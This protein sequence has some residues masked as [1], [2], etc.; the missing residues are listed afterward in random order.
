MKKL[1]L[2]LCCA[3]ALLCCGCMPNTQLE[4]RAIVQAV[5]VD[6]FEDEYHLTLQLFDSGGT[7]ENAGGSDAYQLAQGSGPSLTQAI[8]QLAQSG[9]EVYLGSCQV[10]VL[11]S[12][13]MPKLRDVLD[14]FNSR[15]Q[16]RATMMVCS[17]DGTA[18]DVLNIADGKAK[19]SPAV[20][21]EQELRLGEE[22]KRLPACRLLNILSAL[23]TDGYDGVLPLLGVEGKSGDARPVLKGAVV[24]RGEA[25]LL[26]LSTGEAQ[27]LATAHPGR[28]S[29]GMELQTDGASGVSVLLEDFDAKLKAEW[30]DD[31]LHLWV[32]VKLKG[33]V[34]EWEGMAVD[35]LSQEQLTDAQQKAARQT[36][37]EWN[38]LLQKL[39][40]SGCDPL[41]FGER[42]QRR[43][44]ND[45][46][47]LD[48]RQWPTLLQKA[49]WDIRVT[50]TLTTFSG[51]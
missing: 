21:C 27:L 30:K 43:H 36:V 3:A 22:E 19:P 9:K 14:Y 1:K 5:G 28:G 51:H 7:T 37:D 23:E 38:A 18:A 6:F 4:E 31:R 25:P 10:L 48:S 24:L 13:A 33:R 46:N 47:R 17:T 20:L 39:C 49:D 42:L 45:W 12:R 44:P 32:E 8:Q 41:R 34:S 16:T 29:I 15:P 11:G 26:E 50:C 35:D 40:G 2:I